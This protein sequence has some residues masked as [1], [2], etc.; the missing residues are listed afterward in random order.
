MYTT[1]TT[2]S[3]NSWPLS[4]N[5]GCDLRTPEALSRI[6]VKTEALLAI[7]VMGIMKAKALLA[8]PVID[9]MKAGA[10][11]IVQYYSI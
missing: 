2:V 9:N 10:L 6:R 7:P 4:G 3:A 5:E 1:G 8:V 11:F